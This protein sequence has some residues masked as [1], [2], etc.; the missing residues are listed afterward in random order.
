MLMSGNENFIIDHLNTKKFILS[1]LSLL[2]YEEFQDFFKCIV[3]DPIDHKII[4]LN[5]DWAKIYKA[6]KPELLP[7]AK[8][9]EW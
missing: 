1:K 5:A 7:T 6:L 2:T 4:N 8:I 3:N 9:K